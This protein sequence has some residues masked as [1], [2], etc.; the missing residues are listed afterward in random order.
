MGISKTSRIKISRSKHATSVLKLRMEGLSHREIG[1]RL[2]FSEQRAFK[3]CKDELERLNQVRTEA[4]SELQRL[5]LH[6]L[7]E[8]LKAVYQ[9]AR[10]GDVQ[11][12][13]RVLVVMERRAKLLGLDLADKDSRPTHT[14]TLNVQEM[15]VDRGALKNGRAIDALENDT[16]SPDA[17]RLPA[18]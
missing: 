1:N 11:A 3:I 5:E 12:L 8:M 10:K 7:D 14:V 16:T 15:V 17:K 6:R 4:A 13:D 2:G 18:K 9:K